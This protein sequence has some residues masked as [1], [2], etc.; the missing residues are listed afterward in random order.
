MFHGATPVSAKEGW[1]GFAQPRLLVS[2]CL[3][4]AG[5]DWNYHMCSPFWRLYMHDRPGA[6]IEC[7]GNWWHL[8]SG[9]VHL[10]PAGLTFRTDAQNPLRQNYQHFE[11][12]GLPS[13]LVRL[14]F[15]RPISLPIAGSLAVLTERW[16]EG[17]DEAGEPSLAAHGWALALLNAVVATFLGELP[18][19][20]RRAGEVWRS[21]SSR[22]A[23]ALAR[24]DRH[25]GGP[26]TNDELA[27]L[28]GFSPTHFARQFRA[29]TGMSPAQYGLGRRLQEAARL[30][31]VTDDNIEYIADRVGFSDRFHFAKMFKARLGY[32]PAAYRAMHRLKRG[33]LENMSTR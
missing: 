33:S 4:L 10:V 15:T 2:R 13:R 8:G 21:E 28:C 19:E 32:P 29:G 31:T 30:L 27:R 11:F 1:L 3:F 25:E 22:L 9:E 26:A 12:Q 6:R 24:M 16:S 14:R 18:E 5:G 20:D 7:E 23:P 17:L